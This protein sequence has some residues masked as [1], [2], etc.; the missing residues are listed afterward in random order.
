MSLFEKFKQCFAAIT[1]Y[2]QDDFDQNDDQDITDKEQQSQKDAIL[3]R[4]KVVRKDILKDIDACFTLLNYLKSTDNGPSLSQECE[5]IENLLNSLNSKL[6]SVNKDSKDSDK[7]IND[8]KVLLNQLVDTSSIDIV[9]K[10]NK[11]IEQLSLKDTLLKFFALHEYFQNN[12]YSKVEDIN[13]VKEFNL[14]YINFIRFLKGV[15][16]AGSKD[17]EKTQDEFISYTENLNNQIIA[18]LNNKQAFE[19]F[20]NNF[21]QNNSVDDYLWNIFSLSKENNTK[22]EVNLEKVFDISMKL[23][24]LKTLILFIFKSVTKKEDIDESEVSETLYK[25]FIDS[26]SSK[27][28]FKWYKRG[29]DGKGDSQS[30]RQFML[31]SLYNNFSLNSVSKYCDKSVS[32]MLDNLSKY[33]SQFKPWDTLP[34]DYESKVKNIINFGI[35]SIALAGTDRF[36]NTKSDIDGI[37]KILDYYTK[38]LTTKSDIRENILKPLSSLY[39]G[40]LKLITPAVICKSEL[41][42]VPNR[43]I[44]LHQSGSVDFILDTKEALDFLE[45]VNKSITNQLQVLDELPDVEKEDVVIQDSNNEQL[46]IKDE[47]I[48]D[49]EILN[50]KTTVIK[51]FEFFYN[52]FFKDYKE[53]FDEYNM[54]INN[55]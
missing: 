41:E 49:S 6:E 29:V 8:L 53:K 7:I 32:N 16:V 3:E 23:Y 28:F 21:K 44:S 14:L 39:N 19:D 24:E 17:F 51:L 18:K 13:L 46:E 48:K 54:Y 40:I 11:L 22:F 10:I 42:N 26:V 37:V 9:S 43:D 55:L 2:E 25:D 15:I 5:N 20:E 52:K 30:A 27:E 35:L 12:N 38:N 31:E 4:E 47:I 34:E 1:D 45:E 36:I 33:I 50:V